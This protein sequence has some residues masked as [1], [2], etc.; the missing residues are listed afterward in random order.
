MIPASLNLPDTAWKV[1]NFI[2]F[3]ISKEFHTK[4]LEIIMICYNTIFHLKRYISYKLQ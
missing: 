4:C 3:V 2:V 1:R